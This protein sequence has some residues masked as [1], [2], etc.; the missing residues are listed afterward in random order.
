MLSGVVPKTVPGQH[1]QLFQLRGCAA[2]FSQ[3]L[4]HKSLVSGIAEFIVAS[5]WMFFG[6][7]FRIVR[8]VSISRSAA[9]DG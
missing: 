3:H 2:I 6:Q 4:F 8:V 7:P 5:Q 9:G 1:D